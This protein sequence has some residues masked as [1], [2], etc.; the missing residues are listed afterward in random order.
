MNG[1]ESRRCAWLMVRLQN[2]RELRSNDGRWPMARFEKDYNDIIRQLGW[3][4]EQEAAW[5]EHQKQ[6]P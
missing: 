1:A 6:N 3:S 5:W 2:I 4:P